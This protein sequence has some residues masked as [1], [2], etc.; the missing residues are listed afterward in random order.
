MLIATWVKELS[1]IYSI[2]IVFAKLAKNDYF[3]IN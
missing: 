3:L 1:L 2:G